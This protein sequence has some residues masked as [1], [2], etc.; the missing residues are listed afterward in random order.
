MS[1]FPTPVSTPTH[2]FERKLV[3]PWEWEWKGDRIRIPAGVVYDPSIPSWAS[4]VVPD[5][6]LEPASL[7]HDVIYKLQGHVSEIMSRNDG[8]PIQWVSRGYADRM[9]RDILR[10]QNVP[11]WRRTLAYRAV[12]WFGGPAWREEDDFTL[13]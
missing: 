9:F 13:P 7:P 8:T 11:R 2:S 10:I 12:R 6:F 4:S 1:H 3:E 5:D